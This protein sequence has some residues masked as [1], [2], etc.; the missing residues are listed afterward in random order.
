MYLRMYSLVYQDVLSCISKECAWNKCRYNCQLQHSAKKPIQSLHMVPNL[1]K[2][3]ET[4]RGLVS[5][6]PL[7]SVICRSWS[8]HLGTSHPV[9]G[10]WWVGLNTPAQA[11]GSRIHFVDTRFWCWWT[12]GCDWQLM[13]FVLLQFLFYIKSLFP[14]VRSCTGIATL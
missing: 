14:P 5:C 3:W 8:W 9:P 10:C 1:T 4:W 13:K 6:C 2:T 7:S 11:L 12:S